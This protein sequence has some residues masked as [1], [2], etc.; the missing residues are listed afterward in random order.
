M[1]GLAP[2]GAS[3]LVAV[4]AGAALGVGAIAMDGAAQARADAQ[5]A[6][7]T[8]S[9]DLWG[10]SA[11]GAGQT[12]CRIV[13]GGAS[14]ISVSTQWVRGQKAVL[15]GSG[16][17]VAGSARAFVSVALDEGRQLRP[18]DKQLPTWAQRALADDRQVW[19][20][21]E[22]DAQGSFTAEIAVP[23]EWEAGS[24]HTVVI[25]NGESGAPVTF[26]V[27]VVGALTPLRPENCANGPEKPVP[28][29]PSSSPSPSPSAPSPSV[30]PS[31]PSPSP[32]PSAPSPSVS[33]SPA[34][35]HAP[36]GA[37]PTI[38]REPEL[39]WR[40]G[41]ARAVEDGAAPDPEPVP[42]TAAPRVA[43]PSAAP[44]ASDGAA[45]T[46]VPAVPAAPA[47]TQES[48]P[49]APGAPGRAAP[50][51]GSAGEG[52]AEGPL[53]SG[54]VADPSPVT[55]PA[56]RPTAAQPSASP[57]TEPTRVSADAAVPPN[58]GGGSS[59]ESASGL[60]SWVMVGGAGLLLLGVTVAFTFIR[61]M[62]HPH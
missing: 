42:T 8:S 5:S 19:D 29:E 36:T 9:V 6:N 40:G 45:S 3:R 55:A 57:S 25:S 15:S 14:R 48:L 20:V 11:E 61:R 31:A 51:D 41:G 23:D 18:S 53:G 34:P 30:S 32:S 33:P 44:S 59:E 17:T 27:F 50:Q 13:S 52:A 10:S 24:R 46:Q 54:P 28:A 47:R 26:S 39:E 1:A 4:C 37:A 22:L 16:W 58:A 56:A 38:S 2:T 49:A 12:G 60:N 21:V 35:S 7:L 62:A 43:G